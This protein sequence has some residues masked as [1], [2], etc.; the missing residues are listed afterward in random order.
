MDD[1]C[2]AGGPHSILF[3]DSG[4]SLELDAAPEERR[5][6]LVPSTFEAGKEATF[7]L[8]IFATSQ[9]EIDGATAQGGGR[10]S[11][12]EHSA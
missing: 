5:L 7:T 11:L 9:L 4:I 6:L 10:W 8:C 12:T 1:T 3:G 2:G